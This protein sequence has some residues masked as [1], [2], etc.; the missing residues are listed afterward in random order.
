MSTAELLAKV[1]AATGADHALDVEIWEAFHPN[2]RKA[3]RFKPETFATASIDAALALVERELTGW[4]WLREDGQ[5]IR[6]VGPDNGDCYPSAVGKHH[7]V[8]LAIIAA[9]LT[10]KIA[11]AQP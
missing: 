2:E 9:L 10:A 5:S 7:L 4:W 6:L 1:M 11:Q 8:P 3:K